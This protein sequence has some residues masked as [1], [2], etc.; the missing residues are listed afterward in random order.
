MPTLKGECSARFLLS[1]FFGRGHE[2]GQ[3]EWGPRCDMGEGCEGC[4]ISIEGGQCGVGG[5]EA[6]EGQ[7]DNIHLSAVCYL[8]F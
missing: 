6:K 4:G 3:W 8:P 1:S 7:P 5:M 2:V